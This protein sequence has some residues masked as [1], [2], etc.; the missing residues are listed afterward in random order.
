LWK[1]WEYFRTRGGFANPMGRIQTALS[2][3]VKITI[4]IENDRKSLKS[5]QMRVDFF[6]VLWT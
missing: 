4:W 6:N 1:Y 5:R 2:T 3:T